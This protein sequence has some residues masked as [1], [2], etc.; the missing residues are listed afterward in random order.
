MDFSLTTLFVVPAGNTL[1][2]TGSTENLTDGQFGVFVDQARTIATAANIATSKFVQFAQGRPSLDLGTKVSDKIVAKK[3]K[4][5]YKVTG[6]GTA[7]TETVTISNFTVPKGDDFVLT[8]RLFGFDAELAAYNGFTRSYVVPA[9]CYACG[10]SAC[11]TADPESIVDALIEK[12]NQ[13]A[14][15]QNIPSSLGIPT[16][17]TFTK[18]GTGSATTLTIALKPQVTDSKFCDVALNPFIFDRQYFRAFAY[19]GAETTADFLVS[20]ACNVAATVTINSRSNYAR[21]TSAEIA[22]LEIDYYSYQN[23]HKS[24]FRRSGFNQYFNEQTYVSDGAVY[25]LYAVI[26]DE[27]FQNN[28]WNDFVSEDETVLIAIPQGED[29]AISALITALATKAGVEVEDQTGGTYA[30][31]PITVL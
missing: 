24:L 3:V 26:F 8:L 31:S 10:D 5:I 19:L 16:F 12:Y 28:N 17:Y 20:D 6:S 18:N 11:E 4:Q 15:V 2:T 25:N 9:D 22:Q 30:E 14:S 1:P 21:L 7:T 29:T 23:T 13:E 27:G